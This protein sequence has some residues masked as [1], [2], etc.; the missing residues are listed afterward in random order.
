MGNRDRVDT[1]IDVY[2]DFARR[3]D[4]RGFTGLYHLLAGRVAGYVGGRGVHEVDDVV[5]EVFL[6]AFGNLDTFTGRAPEFRSWL[7]SIAWNKSADWH[8]S[9]HRRPT[10]VDVH[11]Q[12]AGSLPIDTSTDEQL[13][14]TLAVQRI[15]TLL[16]DLT[17]DQRDV[18]MM[19]IVADLSLEETAA[20]LGKP[21]GAV[22]S[23]QHRA[24]ESLRR[25]I[26]QPV[27]GTGPTT[28][29]ESK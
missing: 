21:T 25:K 8:R 22:K 14:C 9:G 7:F 18:L 2:L 1:E 4:Q 19:R 26:T 20:A 29:A 17:A 6:G 15:D 28:I 23:L 24:L 27:S 16:G 11:T 5:N 3:G 10:P 13:D 12:A